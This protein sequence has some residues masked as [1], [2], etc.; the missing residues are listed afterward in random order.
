[1]KKMAMTP[2]LASLTAAAPT[3]A[4]RPSLTPPHRRTTPPHR[5]RTPPH[6]RRTPPQPEED[7]TEPEDDTTEPE[8]DTTEP[9]DDTTEPAGCE[10][11]DDC[12]ATAGCCQAA[13]CNADGVCEYTDLDGCC[14]AS[15]DCDDSDDQTNDVCSSP[16]SEGGCEYYP[17][18]GCDD[19]QTY[20]HENF[21]AG[22]L[23]T[24]LVVDLNPNDSATVSVTTNASVTPGFGLHFGV[25]GCATYYAGDLTDCTPTDGFV[26]DTD[27]INLEYQLA[28]LELDADTSSHL[29][30][31][32]DM[33]AEAAF[34]ADGVVYAVD[35]LGDLRREHQRQ[36]LDLEELR[37]LR[38]H[39]Q[40]RWI[41]ASSRRSQRVGG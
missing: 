25:P 31:W 20:A 34:E 9:E 30:F 35:Y 24:G 7:T 29:S 4:A 41:R 2:A 6:R 1:M 15:S 5:R 14:E 38:N 22:T 18:V 11:D 8:D 13:T 36:Q 10:S 3:T 27:P 26:P 23:G 39:E 40:L 16:C 28:N 32:V 33:A 17:V 37:R 19:G 21:D 12:A